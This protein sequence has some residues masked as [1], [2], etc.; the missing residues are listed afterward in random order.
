MSLQGA[1]NQFK[2]SLFVCGL[3]QRFPA[4]VSSGVRHQESVRTSARG[5]LKFSACGE[6]I[7][8]LGVVWRQCLLCQ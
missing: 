4:S 8:L 5:S 7:V 3:C 6:I 2:G 1:G